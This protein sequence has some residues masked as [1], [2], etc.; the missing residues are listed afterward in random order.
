MAKPK[1]VYADAAKIAEYRAGLPARLMNIVAL[2]NSVGASVDINLIKS[3]PAIRIQIKHRE[4]DDHVV[5][6]TKS[7][8]ETLTYDSEEWQVESV[9]WFLTNR[10]KEVEQKEQRRTL[11]TVCWSSLTNEQRSALK[12]FMHILPNN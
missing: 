11:A 6:W 12:E 9:E 4:W 3:G 1:N 8:D 5:A 10:Q 2:A 7:L